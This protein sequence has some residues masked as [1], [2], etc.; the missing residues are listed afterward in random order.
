[1]ATMVHDRL[2]DVALLDAREVE[3]ALADIHATREHWTARHS[4]HPFFTLGAASYMDARGGRFAEYQAS[5]QRTNPVLRDRFGWL[6]EKVRTAVAAHVGGTV[7]YDE[8]IA[9]PGFH[10]FLYAEDA[11]NASASVHYDQQY[12]LIDWTGIGT[13]DPDTQLSLTLAVALPA[14]GGGLLVWNL[15]RLELERMPPD[16]RKAHM[17]ANRNAVFSPYEVGHLFIHSGH[18]LHQGAPSKALRPDDARITLQCHSIRVDGRWI[19]YW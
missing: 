9:L 16:A 8:R 2:T 14:S 6:L 10:V 4:K 1:M 7:V 12:E 18:Q 15:N 17:A 3:R 5:A 19:V 13:P 11:E